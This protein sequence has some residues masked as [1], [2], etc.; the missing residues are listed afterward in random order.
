MQTLIQV[1]YGGPPNGVQ[2]RI[3]IE[4]IRGWATQHFEWYRKWPGRES[5]KILGQDGLSW[6]IVDRC[7][8]RGGRGLPGDSSLSAVLRTG[9]AQINYGPA[10]RALTLRQ[11]LEWADLHHMR[12]GEWPHRET[13]RL[14][15]APALTWGTIDRRLRQGELDSRHPAS[16]VELLRQ[17]RG[18]WDSRGKSRLTIKLIL[19]WADAH[20]ARF[21]RWPVT[22]SGPVHGVSNENW[23]AVDVAMRNG[24]RGLGQKISLSQL[25][26]RE[27]GTRYKRSLEPVSIKQILSWADAHHRRTDR[28]PTR[29]SGPVHG[30]PGVNWNMVESWLRMGG[31]GLPGGS[32][33]ARLLGEHRGKR[34]RS[35]LPRLSIDLILKW[36]DAH[37]HRTGQWPTRKSGQ[38][39]SAP[40]DT[41]AVID[42]CLSRG[43]RGL[44]GGS[45]LPKLLAQ[46]RDVRNRHALAPLSVS[47]ILRWA[48]A[49]H[50][51]TGQWPSRTSGSVTESP[52]ETWSGIDAALKSNHRGLTGES[53]LHQ[54][55]QR[56]VG[57]T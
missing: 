26:T 54:L 20:Y 15:E 10:K 2:Q 6:G 36:A 19:K 33:L 29:N 31:R 48:R 23:A 16:L 40:Q 46:H 41:W 30:V 42:T 44:D 13:G 18:V 51:R 43:S 47:E 49:H 56:H 12:T 55:L 3:A 50:A 11:L 52:G 14:P 8:K 25:L 1:P 39:E 32:S 28:W 4:Q 34:N 57:H 45:S 22:L 7:L 17:H 35:E 38:I 9:G 24:R 37:L 21:G 53:S 5:G 27:R